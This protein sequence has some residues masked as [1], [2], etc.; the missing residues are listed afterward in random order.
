MRMHVGVYVFVYMFV[1]VMYVC[2]YVYVHE[3]FC[4]NECGGHIWLL[5]QSFVWQ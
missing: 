2:K 4:V 1:E 5:T 3:P